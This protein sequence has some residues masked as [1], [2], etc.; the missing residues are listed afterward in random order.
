VRKYKVVLPNTVSSVPGV[1][2]RALLMTMLMQVMLMLM[3][4]ILMVTMMLMLMMLVMMSKLVQYQD[5]PCRYSTVLSAPSSGLRSA[6]LRTP[7]LCAV[8]CF[9]L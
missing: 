7:V 5:T 6:G 9:P 8:L 3:M 2:P 1:G 4:L